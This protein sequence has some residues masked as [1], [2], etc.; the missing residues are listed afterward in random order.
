MQ[1]RG[2]S[3]PLPR[4]YLGRVKVAHVAAARPRAVL[5]HPKRV[6]DALAPQHPLP[7]VLRLG[8]RGGEAEGGLLR[9]R[10]ARAARGVRVRAPAIMVCG[11][12]GPRRGGPEV[13]AE[14]PAP[15][16]GVA[17]HHRER[18]ECERGERAGARGA[19]RGG[20][21]GVHP[22]PEGRG[23][24]ETEIAA[25]RAARLCSGGHGDGGS[26]EPTTGGGHATL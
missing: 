2:P 6:L 3:S 24:G 20:G 26:V 12:C 7:A 25:Q 4:S 1:G 14:V 10:K 19:P 22:P 5:Q 18:A 17:A 16:A 11:R 8:G 15:P 21:R 9:G 13:L 23:R